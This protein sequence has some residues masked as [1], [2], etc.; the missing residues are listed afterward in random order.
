MNSIMLP[1]SEDIKKGAILTL[2]RDTTG[3]YVR[4]AKDG[5]IPAGVAR[6]DYAQGELV[7]V[8]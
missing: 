5:D 3:V 8:G 1:A 2:H 6:R 4:A 7:P